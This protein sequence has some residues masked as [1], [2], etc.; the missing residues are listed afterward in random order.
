MFSL[1]EIRKTLKPSKTCLTLLSIVLI[2]LTLFNLRSYALILCS[3]TVMSST[4][5]LWR[6][7][8]NIIFCEIV[9]T[10]CLLESASISKYSYCT[11]NTVVQQETRI[12][13]ARLG[14]HQGRSKKTQENYI[15]IWCKIII[16]KDWSSILKDRVILTMFH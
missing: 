7:E 3:F 8:G 5:K 11:S 12:G 6:K 15:K 14:S 1:L 4:N 16:C 9:K 13:W 2:C 10:Y